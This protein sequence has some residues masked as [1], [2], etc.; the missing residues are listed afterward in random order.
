MRGRGRLRRGSVVVAPVVATTFLVIVTAAMLLLPGASPRRIIAGTLEA[1]DPS[2]LHSG[3]RARLLIQRDRMLEIAEGRRTWSMSEIDG[4]LA[5]VNVRADTSKVVSAVKGVLTDS[6]RG[7][8]MLGF[9]DRADDAYY[10]SLSIPE[11]HDLVQR[12]Q[13]ALDAPLPNVGTTFE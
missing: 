5:R 8:V 1:G 11:A 10:V 12:V 13:L 6:G 7:V 9:G 2:L 3:Y 4:G